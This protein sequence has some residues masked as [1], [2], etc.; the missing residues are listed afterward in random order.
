MSRLGINTGSNPNDGQGDPLRVAMGKINSNF[1]EIYNTLGNGFDVVSYASTAG[2]STLAEDLTGNPK[3]NVSGIL[4]T[5]ITTTEHLEVRNI[6][7][8]GVITATQFV[9]D[10]SQLE[11]V[12]ATN[13]GV[14]VLDENVRKGVAKE[15]NFGEGLFC[16]GPDG[17]GRVTIAV[18]TSIVSGGGTGGSPLEIRNQ[19]AI[20]GEYSKL[21]FG[22]N[23]L[24]YVNPITGV[25]TV[26]TAPGL[27]VSGISTFGNVVVGGAST[28][29]V[30]N[31]NARITG[32]LTIGTSSL[33]LDGVNN[34][35][36]IGTGVTIGESGSASFTQGVNVSG[37]ITAT[38]FVGDG[39]GLTGVNVSVA[40]YASNAGVSTYAVTSGV[41]TYSS[42]SVTSGIASALTLTADINTSGVITASSFSG[43]GANLTGVIK[44]LVGYA[45]TGYVDNKV[46]GF[47]TSG[48]LTGYATQGYVT[49]SLVGYATTGYVTSAVSSITLDNLT[50]VNVGAPSTG[51]VL[52]W[53]G[54]AWV[55]S[56]DLTGVGGV[57]IALSD[58]SVTINPAGINSLTYNNTTGVFQFTPTSLVGYATQGY[59]DNAV[60][61]FITS[62]GSVNYASIAGV[63]T[64]ATSSGISTTS[65]GLTGTPNISVNQ[66][67]IAS[68]LSVSG[69]TSFYNDVHIESNKNLIIGD[70]DE[71][72]LFHSGVDSYI[73]NSSSGNLIIRDS[74][75]GIQ[76]RRSGGGPG[77]GLMAAFNNDAGVQLFYNSVLKLQTFQDGVAIND[78]IGIGTTA[79]NP[80]YRLTVSGIGATITSGLENA[81]ADLTSSV[82]GYGQVNIRN[83]R[84]A[85]SASG[86]LV[87]TA[88][89]GTDT[90]NYIDLGI[91]NTGFSTSSWTINGVLDGY[92][93]TSDSNLSIGVAAAGKYLSLFAGGTLA[94]NEKVR[95]TETGVGIGSTQP[96][97]V[98][99]VGG[100]IRVSGVITATA[101][102][103]SLTG[104]STTATNL[105]NAANIIT[106]TISSARLSGTYGINVNYS[107][108]S[109]YS[110]SSG[111]STTSGYATSSGISTTSQGLTGTPNINVGVITA[112]SIIRSGG[113][114]SQF[115][116]ANG[117]IDSNTYL[118][119]T[120]S[121]SGLSNVVN[122][123]IAGTGITIS[124]STGQVT[125]NATGGGGSSNITVQD[126]GTTVGTATTILNFVGSGVAASYSSGI[127]TITVTAS[128][129]GIGT[130]WVTVASGIYTGVNVGVGTTVASSTLTVEGTGRFSGVVTA[131]RFDSVTT[132]TPII[133]S[134]DT[135]SINSPKVAIS[136]DLNVGGT[137]SI[138]ATIT[139][140][141]LSVNGGDLRVGVNTS[142]GLVLTSPNGTKYRLV[143]DNSGNLSTVLVP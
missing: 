33:T 114:S 55:S 111:V 76:I 8:T 96:T 30:V 126:E 13:S 34:Q 88:D 128:G 52:K 24:A 60:V 28:S 4:N 1:L 127:A 16:S 136:T 66:V 75:T 135:I 25:V 14:E 133:E 100:D 42:Y 62:G 94:E 2:I 72:Q 86:D 123:I 140:S 32:I 15:L 63:A 5:G 77:A 64:Y 113:T 65:Q 38:S 50:D 36:K 41:S 20:L 44:S 116:K 141:K 115:L 104:T 132:G 11:N 40:S 106:G 107:S 51:Q 39:S 71:L 102:Y 9:G 45:T 54:S 43:S 95:V 92:L 18:T 27:N 130:Q 109:G 112:T 120:G 138:G 53:S 23:L 134:T 10:G 81:I 6:T 74:G 108:T 125:I 98:L 80:P 131:S 110:T 58:L 49:N 47:I 37:A 91:N 90:S 19:N 89:A 79:G 17:V 59:V 46:V 73:D 87:I 70:N 121:G 118:T 85:P 103:G 137:V 124:N 129:S 61:G 21:N 57:G 31:G 93:Y 82:D 3:I 101:F 97:S 119:T 99:S 22:S 56:S 83:S 29:L 117:S 143:V 105:A 35:I 68:Y 142:Y 26:T 69:I 78:S 67:G 139:G 7:S 84:S 12:I 48:A 122:A